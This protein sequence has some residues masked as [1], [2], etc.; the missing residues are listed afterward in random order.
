MELSELDKRVIYEVTDSIGGE[1]EAV[2]AEL[3]RENPNL[4]LLAL[5]LNQSLGGTMAILEEDDLL[6]DLWDTGTLPKQEKLRACWAVWVSTISSEIL[7]KQPESTQTDMLRIIASVFSQSYEMLSSEVRAYNNASIPKEAKEKGAIDA[8]KP[9]IFRIRLAKSLGYPDVRVPE[10]FPAHAVVMDMHPELR[11]LTDFEKE[12]VLAVYLKHALAEFRDSLTNSKQ[13]S[14]PKATGWKIEGRKQTKQ[15]SAALEAAIK[16]LDKNPTKQESAPK[17]T[18]WKIE[19]RK[20][21]KQESAALEA[22]I[23]RLDKRANR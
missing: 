19:G 8:Y 10:E 13:E 21:T 22:A 5:I 15:E 7:S 6:R 3:G 2:T 23:K 11:P 14:A 20:Q 1:L 16:R 4:K 17:A 12:M 18:G 9:V